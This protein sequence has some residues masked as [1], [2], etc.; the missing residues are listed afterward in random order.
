VA[1]SKLK[2]HTTGRK[3]TLKRRLCA[4]TLVAINRNKRNIGGSKSRIYNT[5]L[6]INLKIVQKKLESKI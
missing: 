3:P 6:F 5:F 4:K 1:E 2:Q